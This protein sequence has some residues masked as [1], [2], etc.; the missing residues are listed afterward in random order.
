MSASHPPNKERRVDFTLLFKAI[1]D[2]AEDGIAVTSEELDEID[3]LRMAVE[4]ATEP[5]A[6]FHTTS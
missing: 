5:E 3:E 4:Q 2:V 1:A 6:T